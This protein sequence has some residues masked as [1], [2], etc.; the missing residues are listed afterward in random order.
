MTGLA[1]LNP[2]YAAVPCPPVLE[3]GRLG[4]PCP[5]VDAEADWAARINGPGVVWYHDF[6]SNAE[7]DAFRWAGGVGND[8][9][10]LGRPGTVRRNT[11][12]G[13]TGNCL[14]IFR[15]AGS[16]DGAVWWRPF[17]P[18]DSGSGKP[19]SDPADNGLLTVENWS[20]T[21]GGAQ[22]S[23]W[24]KGYYG[25]SNYHSSHPGQFD[26]E[27]FYFQ[28]R[29]KVDPR[30]TNQ[31]NGGKLFYF[32]LANRSATSQ[33]IVTESGESHDGVNYFSMYRSVSPPLEGDTPPGRNN[34]PG[35]DLGFCDW[36]GQVSNCWSRSDGW[37][38]FLYR[39]RHGLD[40]NSDTIVQVWAAHPGETEYTKIWDQ[41]TVDLPFQSVEGHNALICSGYMNGQD[42]STD[43]FHRYCQ[44][45]FS[46]QFIACPTV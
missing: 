38:T 41:D 19:V 37:D 7:V 2:L 45:I 4:T 40:S 43:I 3:N 23:K 24:N 44:L 1:Y 35:S 39:I 42:F 12:D 31:S 5:A 30:R 11:S 32:T 9:N 10:D 29:V 22:T 34:Q 18:M 14:E 16:A 26:G 20:P 36:P 13:I 21:Q 33:E 27:E 8:P 25:N 46:R 6:R 15:P 17:S 28:A